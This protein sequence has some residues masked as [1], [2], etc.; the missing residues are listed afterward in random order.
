M[1]T[2]QLN[3]TKPAK[4]P[5]PLTVIADVV[6]ETDLIDLIWSS[7]SERKALY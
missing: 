1:A 6:V 7:G 5:M 3:I 4:P 2:E